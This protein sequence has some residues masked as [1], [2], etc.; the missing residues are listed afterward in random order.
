VTP[1]EPGGPRAGPRPDTLDRR[2]AV[3]VAGTF[4]MEILDG[5]ILSTAAPDIAGSLG[6]RPADIGVAITAYLVT[7]AVLIPLSGWLAERWGTRTVFITAI[8]IFTVSSGLCALST[9]LAELTVLRVLQGAGGALMVPVGRLVVLRGTAKRDVIRAIAFLTWPALAAP[10]VAPLAGGL[11]TTYLSW[12]WIFLINLPLGAVALLAAVKLVPQ[13]REPDPAPMD[14]PGFLQTSG[15]LAAL[16]LALSALGAP[17]IN[18][19]VV[20]LSGA[21]ALLLGLTA[22]GHL[23]RAGRP[24]LD[25]TLLRVRTFRVSH[26]GGGIYRATVFAVPFVLPL[27]FQ[28]A[29]GWSAVRAGALVMAV[30]A[31]NFAIKPATTA[32]LRRWSF[33]TVIV[34][35]VVLVS[36]TM[37]LF[38]AIGPQ[39]P[40]PALVV[41]LV[42][43]GAA[44]SVGF[45]AYGTIMFAD[46]DQDRMTAANT[47]SSTLQQLAGGLGVAV[48]ALGLQIG[49]SIGWFGD[50]PT[51]PI[52]PYRITFVLLAVITLTSLWEAFRMGGDAGH[53]LR[54]RA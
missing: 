42:I 43:S 27:M 19:P 37:L 12:H 48:G 26:A 45:T 53:Q 29:F 54:A 9:S 10:I 21:V 5:T 22:V 14:W 34:W 28:E 16:V 40:V 49:A 41:L 18:W 31:G 36:V 52:E 15:A 3:L 2:L 35:S 6:V 24:L 23:L 33:R 47:L 39:T 51:Q 4:F 13:L 44:R 7:L 46:I 1:A 11:L 30:F 50:A 20:V 25:L 38:A 8:A 17:T 32:I